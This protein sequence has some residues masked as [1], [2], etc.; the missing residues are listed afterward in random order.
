MLL[1]Q[2]AYIPTMSLTNAICFHHVKDARQDFGRIRLWG[3]IGWIAA[4]WPFVFILA[5]K[6]GPA[7]TR[8]WPASSSSPASP[9]SRWRL[10]ADA[11]AHASGA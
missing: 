2:L 6:T 3:T 10:L 8:R 5:G 9:R 4:S 7:L 1:Y 11:A